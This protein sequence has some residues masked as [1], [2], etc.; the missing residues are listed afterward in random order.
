MSIT[1]VM[2]ILDLLSNRH[3]PTSLSELSRELAAPKASLLAILNELAKLGFLRREQD[4]R[5]LLGGGAYRLAA[6]MTASGSIHQ[7]VRATLANVGR[8][9]KATTSLGYLDLASRTL[10][11]ADRHGEYSAVRYMVKYGPATNIQS[12]A[13]GK[14]LVAMQPEETWADWFGPEP[15][16]KVGSRSHTTFASLHPDLVRSRKERAAYTRSEHYEGISGCA[17]PIL[18][19][20]GQTVAALGL[21]MITETFEREKEHVLAVLRKAAHT[22]S[23]EFD[24]LGIST[25]NISAYL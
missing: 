9:L 25:T 21:L 18:A 11:Y 2:G 14:I 12:R 3:G 8:E 10:V 16:A 24:A 17:V 4:G 5:Y 20:D 22:L 7:T 1:R 19:R 15:Y 23:E 13:T 6:Q